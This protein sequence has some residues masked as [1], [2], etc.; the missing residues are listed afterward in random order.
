MGTMQLQPTRTPNL[1]I[2]YNQYNNS[3]ARNFEVEVELMSNDRENPNALKNL[4]VQEESLSLAA[5]YSRSFARMQKLSH[6]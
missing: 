4:S 2:S 1:L 3:D 6:R 5:T